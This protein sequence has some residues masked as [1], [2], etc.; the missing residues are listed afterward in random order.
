MQVHWLDRGPEREE[1]LISIS[2][3]GQ[4]VQWSITKGLEH[5]PLIKLKRIPRHA[6]GSSAARGGA[7]R[8]NNP[9][10][11]ATSSSSAA[12]LASNSSALLTN[13]VA[14]DAAGEHEAFI[15]RSTGGMSFDFSEKD[16][17]IYLAGAQALSY[18]ALD[19]LEA[20]QLSVSF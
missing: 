16:T 17:R 8:S 10:G 2:T 3:D 15:S 11:L 5:T 19:C 12:L 18:T 7:G 20:C 13:G 1:V 4:V 9:N 14:A 6:P